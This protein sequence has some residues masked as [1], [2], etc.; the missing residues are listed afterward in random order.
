MVCNS[1]KG[2]SK[3]AAQH[4]SLPCES[5]AL[6]TGDMDMVGWPGLTLILHPFPTK[7]ACLYDK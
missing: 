6:G 2:Y 7:M 3:L 4:G 1:N 5:E